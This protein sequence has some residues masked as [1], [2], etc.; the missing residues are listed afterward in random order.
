M[1]R[2]TL[3]IGATAFVLGASSMA[4]IG[5]VANA[6]TEVNSSAQL[7]RYEL[8]D[9][10]LEQ[11]RTQYVTP[12]D[13][14]KLIK[15]AIDGMLASL[16]PHSSYLDAK[17]YSDMQDTTKGSYGGLGL[18][19]TQEEGAVRVI[20]P[21]EDTPASRAG[22]QSGDFIIAIDGSGI[23]GQPLNEAINKMK[24]EPGQNITLTLAR[25]GVDPFDVTLKREIIKPKAATARL[26]GDVGYLK[27]GSGFNEKTTN[28]A[29]AAVQ[30]L[31][32]ENPR[33]KGL[34]LDLRGNPGGLLD[35]AVSVSDLFLDGGEVVSQ[36]GRDAS[37]IE[38]YNARA[39]DILNGKP[40]VV[41]VNS[42]SASAA[43]IVAGALQDRR[44]AEVVGV[45]SYGKGSVQTLIPL[46]GGQD[47][48]LK[49]TTARYY[50][51]SGRSIQRTGISPDL[52]VASSRAEAENLAKQ[53]Y[54]AS[55]ASQWNA[56]DAD[57]GKSRRGAHDGAE[58]PP[59][60][61]EKA[62]T[63]L[64][65]PQVVAK[66]KDC[67]FQL[68]RAIAVVQHGSVANTP[69]VPGLPKLAAAGPNIPGLARFQART[70]GGSTA[71]APAPAGAAA[72]T[73]PNAAPSAETKAPPFFVC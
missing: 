41:L 3:L 27:L 64:T 48:A 46:H 7:R 53:T 1:K 62:C 13:D 28:E 61:F 34:V 39:G 37:D 20:S 10:I 56:L 9:S 50:T 51:P 68:T 52:E 23:L 47:G 44:R 36:R 6:R 19:V 54:Q 70:A 65:R 16:D 72:S 60:D 42:G 55:E 5:A 30:R 57:T 67:D 59:E 38:R 29:R 8:F 25:E 66:G 4:Y 21:M 73:A 18:E 31:L 11:A 49:L 33:M 14:D 40:I 2:N 45:T 26:E 24:G 43:E 22:I 15:A 63:G 58:A 32:T 71:A 17:A 35:Q 12:V 69:K